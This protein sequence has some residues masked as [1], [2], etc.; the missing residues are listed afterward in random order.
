MKILRQLA[1]H[2]KLLIG[3]KLSLGKQEIE[4]LSEELIWF[5]DDV[6]KIVLFMFVRTSIK[7][8]LIEL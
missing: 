3:S 6:S 4:F 7:Y 8:L 2:P 5:F 1:S